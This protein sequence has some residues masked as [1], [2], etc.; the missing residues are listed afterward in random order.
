LKLQIEIPEGR[1]SSYGIKL[2]NNYLPD[3]NDKIKEEEDWEL[4]TSA[5][6]G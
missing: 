3:E 1:R 4:Q 5:K 2:F 6:R